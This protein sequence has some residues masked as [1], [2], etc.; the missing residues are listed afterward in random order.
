MKK[1]TSPKIKEF[2]S[3]PYFNE[4]VIL[5]KDSSWPK[6]SIVTSSYNQA[7]FLEKDD[8]LSSKPKLSGP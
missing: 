6:I 8:P 2:V 4:K 7:R 5:R 3:R 1:F